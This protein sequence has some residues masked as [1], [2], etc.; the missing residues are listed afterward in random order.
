MLLLHLFAYFARVNFYAFSLPLCVRGCDS[1]IIITR[2]VRH[3]TA[4]P[5]KTISRDIS[6]ADI[7]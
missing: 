2:H 4:T 1:L 7:C 5:G 6:L 3:V